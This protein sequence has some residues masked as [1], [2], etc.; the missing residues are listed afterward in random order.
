M[1]N[2]CFAEYI[3]LDGSEPTQELRSK[4]RVVNVPNN[5]TPS[6]FP[7]WSFDGSST[8]QA[9]GDDS[10]CVLN[11]VCVV[12]DPA[13]RNGGYLVLCEVFDASGDAHGANHRAAL[14]DL[15][16]LAGPEVD[17]WAGFEQEYTIYQDG[18]PLGFPE[19]GMPAPQGP[20]Y[21]G[22][23]SDV[24]FG[25]ALADAHAEL[26][27]EAGLLIYGINAE[28][29]PGQWEFQIGYRG[30]E[31][32]PADAL[33]MA[34]HVW[35]ARFLLKREAENRGLLI[36]FS[37]KP[38]AGD[39][40]GA[41]MHTNFSTAATRAPETGSK[42]IEIAI[43]ALSARHDKHIAQYG[44]GLAE[45]LT[46][47]HETCAIEDFRAGVAHRGASIRIPQPVAEKGYG[48]F[49]DRRP[50][51]N[52]DP[53]RVVACLIESIC[54]PANQDDQPSSKAVAAE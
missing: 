34:D 47:L 36:S 39:W 19:H 28:V 5:P 30:I 15:L 48:Y 2:L 32:E 13:S 26:C 9:P 14:R 54:L 20:Y 45:R 43:S 17:P 49:E 37:N 3:W 35:L 41:G 38:V 11:P 6:D 8:S 25:R 53:Y 10:D 33:T 50:G 42:A 1:T 18:R 51:A 24:A 4:A 22:V 29:M 27:L 12:K 40:N 21:C 23:G 7:S 52:A 16:F 31:G 44:D 46:G